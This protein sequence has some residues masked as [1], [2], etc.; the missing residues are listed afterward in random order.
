MSPP[1]FLLELMETAVDHGCVEVTGS[2]GGQLDDRY[3]FGPDTVSIALG[4]D[5]SLDHGDSDFPLEGLNGV[6]EEGGLA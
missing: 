1:V 6:F 3:T 4:L 5:V 2:A